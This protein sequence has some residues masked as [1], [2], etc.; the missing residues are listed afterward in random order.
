MSN[1]STVTPYETTSS[2][3][4]SGSVAGLAAAGAI[5]CVVGLATG[6]VALGQW[7]SEETEQDR[8]ALD[9]LKT[10]RR[11]ELL[12]GARNE[13]LVQSQGVITTV[14]LQL[15]N[16]ESLVKT[17]EKLG[18][19]LEPLAHA[20]Q[21]LSQRP[22]IL[23]SGSRGERLAIS[24]SESGR[25][26]VHTAG[27]Q[28]RVHDLVRHHSVD[29]ATEHLKSK[30]MVVRAVELRGGEVQIHAVETG[31]TR[32]GGAAE[33]KAQVNVD[34]NT[35]IDVDKVV[36]KRCEEIVKDFAQAVGGEVVNTRRKA[37]YFQLPGEPAKTDIKV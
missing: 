19:R 30:G 4:S 10:T 29:R 12:Q 17:A 28:R 23:L 6:A 33:I 7:L 34:G 35:V 21:P 27:D 2:Q 9:R 16:P 3:D 24:R 15:K 11:A 31:P 37:S 32:K 8:E 18:Y 13:P 26:T 1:T 36:G 20:A 14:G 22:Q 25:L 5:A